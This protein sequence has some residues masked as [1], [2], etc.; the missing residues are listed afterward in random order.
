MSLHHDWMRCVFSC[1]RF[2]KLS[3]NASFVHRHNDN[4]GKHKKQTNEQNRKE[5]LWVE[6]VIISIITLHKRNQIRAW[7]E[8]TENY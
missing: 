6:L 1:V 8:D 7:N 5:R 3:A 2:A 4:S